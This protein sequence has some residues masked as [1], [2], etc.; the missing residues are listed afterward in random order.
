MSSTTMLSCWSNYIA[1]KSRQKSFISR[2]CTLSNV[3]PIRNSSSS[4]WL[5]WSTGSEE[6]NVSP[7]NYTVT[8]WPL[9]MNFTFW[10]REEG[11]A[12]ALWIQGWP[13]SRLKDVGILKTRNKVGNVV[14]SIN[15]S[16]SK[17]PITSLLVLSYAQTV[18]VEGPK[19]KGA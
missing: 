6:I 14:G 10:W 18:W 17:M 11:M 12:S 1:T 2:A 8:T 15:N 9:W 13:N 19:S 16:I 3:N 7:K 4:L 5:I